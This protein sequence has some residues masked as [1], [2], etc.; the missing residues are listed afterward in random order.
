MASI[1]QPTAAQRRILQALLQH[2]H[3]LV[4]AEADGVVPRRCGVIF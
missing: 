3:L 4:L 2:E 1:E